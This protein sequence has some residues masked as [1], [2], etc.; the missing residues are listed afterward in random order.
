[1]LIVVLLVII[2]LIVILLAVILSRSTVFCLVALFVTLFTCNIRETVARYMALFVAFG[3]RFVLIV[4][5]FII[6]VVV[7][8]AFAIVIIILLT[9]AHLGSI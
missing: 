8:F 7:A 1:M 3:A 5:V 9:F 2:L 4:A 6:L